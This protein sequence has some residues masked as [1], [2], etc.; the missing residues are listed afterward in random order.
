MNRILI[1][2][3]C[4]TVA[5][6]SLAAKEERQTLIRVE[7]TP[8]GAEVSCDGKL[9]GEAPVSL[10]GLTTGPHILIAEKNGCRSARETIV[11]SKG[12]QST[13]SMKLDQLP[14]LAVI[15]SDPAGAEV[16]IDGVSHGKTPLL[17]ADLAPGKYRVKLE[18][19]GFQPKE[20]ELNA[21]D[22]TP[23]KLNV[24][25]RSNSAALDIK[26]RPSGAEVLINGISKGDTPLNVDRIPAGKVE[27]E[28]KAQG[29]EPYKNLLT[30]SAGQI[31]SITAVLEPIPSTLEVSSI[32][33][34]ARVYVDNEFRGTTPLK[35]T[36]LEPGD[37]RVRAEKRGYSLTPSRNVTLKRA[38]VAREEFRLSKNAGSME[39]TTQPAGIKVFVDGEELGVTSAKQDASDA[40]SEPLVIDLL[41]IGK[42]N[43]QLT[44]PGYF[45]KDFE[46][47]IEQ[48][49]TV[50]VHHRLRRM[51][52]KNY[53]VRTRDATYEGMLL[54]KT[55]TGGVKLEIRPGII[56]TLSAG[57]IISQ[58]P[59]RKEEIENPE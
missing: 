15:H 47:E 18:A 39:I 3:A 56:K 35:L 31:E 24:S 8:A 54:G 19:Q 30:L 17:I 16:T 50:S 51:F 52:I 12:E 58:A 49:S 34:G 42:H 22:R 23:V 53:T 43:V 36:D 37:Y 27:L 11:V 46:V 48:D 13:V 25:L 21:P 40:V 45:K 32:P 28:I 1:Y 20:V 55:L 5:T 4:L 10:R 38:D 2:L 6:I 44:R 59:I 57:E 14:V 26:S 9:I 29:C 41:G 7:T 33:D